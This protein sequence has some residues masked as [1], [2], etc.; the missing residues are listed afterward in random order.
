MD[1]A[2]VIPFFFQGPIAG[3]G[4][5]RVPVTALLPPTGVRDAEL[6]TLPRMP[7]LHVPRDRVNM[8]HKPAPVPNAARESMVARSHGIV[9]MMFSRV[10][11]WTVVQLHGGERS[12]ADGFV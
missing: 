1:G 5:R 2:K 8:V 7:S 3:K 11:V 6:W 4:D 12:V 10:I 9:R